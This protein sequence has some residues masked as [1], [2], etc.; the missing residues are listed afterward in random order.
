[1]GADREHFTGSFAIDPPDEAGYYRM[2][3]AAA[4]N[5]ARTGKRRPQ[6]MSPPRRTLEP[7][8]RNEQ[9]LMDAREYTG[10]KGILE[11]NCLFGVYGHRARIAFMPVNDAKAWFELV[12]RGVRLSDRR[13]VLITL[14]AETT[15][16]G[17]TPWSRLRS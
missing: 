1:M 17:C 4:P 10:I 2:H 3:L 5:G 12:R 14:V 6:Q 16:A 9:I 13:K 11:Q 8:N 7:C 15:L